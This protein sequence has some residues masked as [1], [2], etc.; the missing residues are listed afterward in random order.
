MLCSYSWIS[1]EA[2]WVLVS[3]QAP[4]IQELSPACWFTQ[5]YSNSS[6]DWSVGKASKWILCCFKAH[7][8]FPEGNGQSSTPFP[9]TGCKSY[10]PASQVS[11][12]INALLTC[13]AV[14][15]GTQ[16]K[17]A[18]MDHEIWGEPQATQGEKCVLGG[19]TVSLMFLWNYHTINWQNKILDFDLLSQSYH[20]L[21]WRSF[22]CNLVTYQ[23]V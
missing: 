3:N 7:R 4:D 18:V 17:C 19:H 2:Y 1:S 16:L 21:S 22:I 8:L 14:I 11:G 13:S 12:K 15:K 9:N 10:T 5:V 20:F 23:K 6:T